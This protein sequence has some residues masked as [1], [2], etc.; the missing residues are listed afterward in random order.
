M[1]Y[2]QREMDTI[3]KKIY[4]SVDK[5]CEKSTL[6]VLTGDHGMNEVGN[7][8]GSSEHETSP[9]LVFMSPTYNRISNLSH[10]ALVNQEQSEMEHLNTALFSYISFSSSDRSCAHTVLT[11]WPTDP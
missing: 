1:P 5:G 10:G 6:V 9:A 8:G 4:N 3:I 11:I 2:K 7:H